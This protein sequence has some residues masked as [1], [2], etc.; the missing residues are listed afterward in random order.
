MS[1]VCFVRDQAYGLLGLSNWLCEGLQR[2]GG[3]VVLMSVFFD[4]RS[5]AQLRIEVLSSMLC[6][7]R[8][9]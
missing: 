2:A 1:R 5:P 8:I 3:L 6:H 7:W 9:D 4:R